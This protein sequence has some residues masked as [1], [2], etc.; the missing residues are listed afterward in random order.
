MILEDIFLLT[1][2]IGTLVAIL[3][4]FGAN[5]YDIREAKKKKQVAAHPYSRQFK[6][7]PLISV[8]ISTH[9]NESTIE[10]CIG[11]LLKSSY[12]KF[13]VIIV[14]KASDDKTKDIIKGLMKEYAHRPIRLMA[15][16]SDK[17]INSS[18]IAYK[19]YGSGE[20]VMLLEATSIL[21]KKALSNAAR[22]FNIEQG[23]G[24]LDFKHDVQFV[25]STIGLFQKYENLLQYGSKKFISVSKSDYSVNTINVLCRSDVFMAFRKHAKKTS[26]GNKNARSY[27]ANDAII[28][29]APMPSFFHL[30]RQR[31]RLQRN[32][33]RSIWL[34]RKLFFRNAPD[35]TKFLTWFRLPLA[36]FMGIVALFVPILLT[37]FLYMT[38][39]LREPDL[40]LLSCAVLGIF[41]LSAI[42]SDDHLRLHRKLVLIL[43]LPVTYGVFYV[44]SFVQIFAVLRSLPFLPDSK[45]SVRN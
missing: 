44:M 35:Y 17:R 31:Y 12:R 41:L 25:Y 15:L 22:H 45:S 24:V 4:S 5:V 39:K 21:D 42:W 30:L 29:T 16:R 11:S 36:V 6:K 28:Y 7:R 40:L 3:T 37:Y 9:N 13:E 38:V 26:I 2:G 20:L 8:I 32:R 19:K 1:A 43:L 27:Y 14:D 10:Q 18:Q 34:Q 33:A 23:I